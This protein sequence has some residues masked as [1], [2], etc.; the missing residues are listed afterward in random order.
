MNERRPRGADRGS[1]D[2]PWSNLPPTEP[3]V[4]RREPFLNRRKGARQREPW[5]RNWK[6][7]AIIAFLLFIAPPL[8][9]WLSR[10]IIGMVQ[11]G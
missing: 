1:Y 3:P 9:G 10:L 4:R 8:C 2:G 5:I 6:G 7:L 11:G